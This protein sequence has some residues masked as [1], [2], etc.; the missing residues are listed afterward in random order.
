MN[1][2]IIQD[3]N[4]LFNVKKFSKE[5]AKMCVVFLIDFFSEY[6]QVILIEKFRDLTAFMIFLSL[7][8]MIRFSQ[9]AINS[10]T[11]FVRIIIKILKKYIVTLR[12]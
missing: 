11:Q 9:S 8:R 10:I 4:L 6:D 7:L 3:V 1:E 5:F 2:I 12:C